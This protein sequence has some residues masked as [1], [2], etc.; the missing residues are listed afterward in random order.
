MSLEN[1]KADYKR[2]MFKDIKNDSIE[3]IYWPYLYSWGS[4]VTQMVKS[5]P[6]S[7]RPRFDP[8]DGKIPWRRVWQSTPVFLPGE[9]CGQRSLVATVH[10]V[11]KSQTR[12]T[13]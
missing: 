13:D 6:A 9:S 11:M 8:W 4:L 7:W 2:K 1:L 5:P 10:V 12:L 3:L